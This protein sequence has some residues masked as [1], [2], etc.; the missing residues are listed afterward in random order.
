VE[1]RVIT[2]AVDEELKCDTIRGRKCPR[3]LRCKE[4]RECPPFIAF[5]PGTC[6]KGLPRET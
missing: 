3:D 5:C 1:N 2:A 6:V 4:I